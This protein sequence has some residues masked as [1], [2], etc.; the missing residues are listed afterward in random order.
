[1]NGQSDVVG[2]GV[3]LVGEAILPGAS[4]MLDGRVGNGLLHTAASGL[5]LAMLGPIGGL[6]SIAIRLNSFSS[7]VNNRNLWDLTSESINRRTGSS[8]AS[9]PSKGP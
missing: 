2:N 3:K 9:N 6:V 7:S 1:M 4:Q 5:A 8:G